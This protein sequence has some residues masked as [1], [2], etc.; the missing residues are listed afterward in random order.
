MKQRTVRLQL[1]VFGVISVVVIV[2]TLFQLLGVKIT[3]K[4]F[5]MKVELHTAGGIFK[6]AEVAYRGVAIGTVKRMDLQTSGVTITLAIDHG[7][8]VPDNSIAHVY[9]LSAVGEQYLDFEPPASPSSTYL[10]AGSV[11]PASQTTTPLQTATVLYDLE[12]FVNSINAGDLQTI[13]TEGAAAFAGTGP[14]L[15]SILTNATIIINQLAASEDSTLDLLKNAAVLLYS[16]AAHSSDFDSFASSVNA[17]TGTLAAATPTINLLAQQAAPT[18]V[19]VN[20]LIRNNGSAIGVLL[21]NLA[22]LSRIQVARI[23]GLRSLLVA[24]PE[25]GRL[26]P[27]LVQDGALS[28][29]AAANRDQQLCPYGVPM[30]NP[31]SG[32]RTP[33]KD[34]N[35]NQNILARGAN[36]APRPGSTTTQSDGQ[37]LLGAS[38]QA[39][40][41]GQAQ[42]GTYD[43]NTGLVSTADGSLVRL[44]TSG[45]QQS[46]LGAN[47]WQA[48]LLAVTGG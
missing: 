7:T 19:L 4:P 38:A 24:V 12:Q 45:G 10:H 2:Y 13:G 29:A 16:A 31:I 1:L 47:S 20:D 35:C 39:T 6:G 34:V 43:P 22:G 40:P 11:V 27:G 23:P 46:L 18:T 28:G 48:L 33:L 3:D 36:Q 9:N 41:S 25:F 17:L 14:D 37:A 30:S 42:V 15:Q 5:A 8:L 32:D 44:G 26:A 21:G